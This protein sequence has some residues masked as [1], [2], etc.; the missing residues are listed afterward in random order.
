MKKNNNN[1]TR[2]T[3]SEF[4]KNSSIMTMKKLEIIAT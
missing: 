1:F 2:V 3:L 4:V